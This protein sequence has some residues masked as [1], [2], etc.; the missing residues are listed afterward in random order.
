[1]PFDLPRRLRSCCGPSHCLVFAQ[2]TGVI[3]AT[4]LQIG[5]GRPDFGKRCLV[6]N[7][8]G[9][10]VDGA[11]ADLMDEAD[12]LVFAGYYAR[13]DLPPRYFRI[14]NGLTATSPV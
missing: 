4:R 10:V 11:T 13:D 9:N 6:Q 14:D 12:I 2:I 1:M 3:E 7:V 8:G 5:P